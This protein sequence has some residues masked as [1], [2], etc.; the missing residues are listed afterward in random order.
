MYNGFQT[1]YKHNLTHLTSNSLLTT[2]QGGDFVN[3][4]GTGKESIYGH[5]FPDENFQHLHDQPG[6]LSMANSGKDTN[7]CQF[8]LTC[9]KADWLDHKHGTWATRRATY[10]R[11]ISHT[12]LRSTVVF[13]QVLDND[14]MMVVRKIENAPV[15]GNKPR[16]P[17]KIVQCGEL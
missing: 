6:R 13:G 9:A 3:V 15:D 4:D 16:I 8:F 2:F 14:S 10:C 1:T 12:I 7:G 11:R 5:T 17:I